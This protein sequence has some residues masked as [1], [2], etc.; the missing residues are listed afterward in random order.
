MSLS[1]CAIYCTLSYECAKYSYHHTKTDWEHFCIPRG[2]VKCFRGKFLCSPVCNVCKWM[3]ANYFV[4][5]V[6]AL[7]D[8][9]LQNGCFSEIRIA[10]IDNGSF[11][12]GQ[13]IFFQGA[14]IA[15]NTL[16]RWRGCR[17]SGNISEISTPFLEQISG[18]VVAGLLV[19]NTPCCRRPPAPFDGFLL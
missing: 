10:A 16:S 7:C 1:F 9:L 11:I 15:R 8:K 14:F 2:R 18:G 17:M 12:E 19:V 6:I 4:S 5:V 13:T 3:F